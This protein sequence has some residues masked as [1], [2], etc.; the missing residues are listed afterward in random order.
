MSLAGREP[1][2]PRDAKLGPKHDLSS[3]I[4]DCGL[5]KKIPAR[6]RSYREFTFLGLF[7]KW[8]YGP[9]T[10]R[11]LFDIVPIKFISALIFIYI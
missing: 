11:E 5:F 6:C 8:W 9:E 1:L 4:Q 7:G 2:T 10:S 3:L